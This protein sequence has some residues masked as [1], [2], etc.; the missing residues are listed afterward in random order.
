MKIC[1][2]NRRAR[3]TG[4]TDQRQTLDICYCISLKIISLKIKKKHKNIG[5]FFHYMLQ[6]NIALGVVLTFSFEI[7]R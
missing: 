6:R 5:L 4:P 2:K 3:S 7:S 1:H